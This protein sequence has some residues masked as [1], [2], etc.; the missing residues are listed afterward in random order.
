MFKCIN[1]TANMQLIWILHEKQSSR[2]SV[3]LSKLVQVEGKVTWLHHS[4]T[5]HQ[6]KLEIQHIFMLNMK[7]S[8]RTVQPRKN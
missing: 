4:P 5:V 2:N 6:F 7:S 3:F 8:T 1:K